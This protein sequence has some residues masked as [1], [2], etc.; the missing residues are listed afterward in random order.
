M[1]IQKVNGKLDFRVGCILLCTI[2]CFV[3]CARKGVKLTADQVEERFGKSVVLVQNQY[4]YSADFGKL[5]IYFTGID[6]DGDLENCET[7][8]DSIKTITSYGTGFFVSEDGKIATNNHVV[9]PAVDEDVVRS[10]FNII[11]GA[12][13]SIYHDKV[14][15]LSDKISELHNYWLQTPSGSVE[16]A[17]IEQARETL[18]EQRDEAQEIADRLRT[19]DVSKA[20][21]AL[22]SK[23]GIAYNNTF[24]TNTSDFQECVVTKQDAEHDLAVVQLKSK[25]T[26]EDCAAFDVSKDDAES[27]NAPHDE[28]GEPID[29]DKVALGANLYLIGYNLG[30]ALALTKDGVKAQITE[31]KISQNTDDVKMMYTIPALRGSSG[32]PIV[33]EYGN[34]VGVNFAGLNTTQSFNYG[35]KAKY[36]RRLLDIE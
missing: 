5:T 21:V 18:K 11:K 7:D 16:E 31:G 19:L 32:S 20:K 3:S 30:P 35:I 27:E 28:S 14:N 9:S 34:F 23:V 12:F 24:I 36:L 13:E 33:D 10:K 22:H 15:E 29:V 17:Q 1:N 2:T 25:K 26:P 6:E 4:Y 8:E